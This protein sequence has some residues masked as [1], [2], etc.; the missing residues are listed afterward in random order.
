MENLLFVG[1]P[2]LKHIKVPLLYSLLPKDLTIQNLFIFTSA[3][4]SPYIIIMPIIFSG[5]LGSLIS[6]IVIL[7]I[8]FCLSRC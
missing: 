4:V 3:N 7:K 1:V 6:F 5:L 2:I 8:E